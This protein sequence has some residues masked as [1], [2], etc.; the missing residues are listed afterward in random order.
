MDFIKTISLRATLAALPVGSTLQVPQTLRTENAVRNAANLLK[1]SKAQ[2]YKVS[3][4]DGGVT[5]LRLA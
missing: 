2:V 3:R 4:Y 5:V 1:R